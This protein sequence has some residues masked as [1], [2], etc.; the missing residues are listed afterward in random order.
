[1]G[2]NWKCWAEL[3]LPVLL[4]TNAVAQERWF[5]YFHYFSSCF[6]LP[7]PLSNFV[8]SPPCN[9]HLSYPLLIRDFSTGIRVVLKMRLKWKRDGNNFPILCANT[10]YCSFLPGKPL[11][12]ALED[13][14]FVSKNLSEDPLW[15]EHAPL[16]PWKSLYIWQSFSKNFT[17]DVFKEDVWNWQQ[18]LLAILSLVGFTVWT[19]L[20]Q[21]VFPS[22]NCQLL[23]HKETKCRYSWYW[24]NSTPTTEALSSQPEK[25]QPGLTGERK[26]DKTEAKQW[27]DRTD[28]EMESNWVRAQV[29]EDRRELAG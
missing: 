16:F 23:W 6:Q 20:P 3:L 10:H 5:F 15:W 19:E 2:N 26:R 14:L 29:K 25:L 4:I 12:K 27:R 7:I 11:F 1:M 22:Q 24:T 18:H 28:K 8:W 17:L 21:R 9:I 13:N